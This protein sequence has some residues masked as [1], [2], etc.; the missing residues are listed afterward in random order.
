M[1]KLVLIRCN[2]IRFHGRQVFISMT[3]FNAGVLVPERDS[4]QIGQGNIGMSPQKMNN[5]LDRS[6]NDD[7]II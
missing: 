1:E 6:F 3:V 4:I 5:P 2:L 7:V